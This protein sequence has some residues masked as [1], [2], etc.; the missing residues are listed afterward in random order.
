MFISSVI[1]KNAQKIA[2][3]GANSEKLCKRLKE[4]ALFKKVITKR[5]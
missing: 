5:A 2:F 4:G 3:G 1:D